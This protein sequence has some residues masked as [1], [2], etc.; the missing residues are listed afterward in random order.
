MCLKDVTFYFPI[1]SDMPGQLPIVEY[2]QLI[3]DGNLQPL[4]KI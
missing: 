4:R 1:I 3:W 2:V